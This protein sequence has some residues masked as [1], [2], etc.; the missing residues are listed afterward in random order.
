[1]HDIGI[2]DVAM[3][4]SVNDVQCHML[5]VYC[6]MTRMVYFLTALW[7]E[8]SCMKAPKEKDSKVCLK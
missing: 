7:E 4:F 2:L 1:M 8:D 6:H 3:H 5:K